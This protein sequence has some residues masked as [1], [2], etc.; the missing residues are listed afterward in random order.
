MSAYEAHYPREHCQEIKRQAAVGK[1]VRIQRRALAV[2]HVGAGGYV[3]KLRPGRGP[4]ERRIAVRS[5]QDH[6]DPA[7]VG[8]ELV[9]TV[10]V[11]VVEAKSTAQDENDNGQ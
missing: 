11:E 1:K 10:P 3:E 9:S 6:V 5:R 4:R 8:M 2:G 7:L